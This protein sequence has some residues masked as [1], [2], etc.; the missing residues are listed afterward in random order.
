[1]SLAIKLLKHFNGFGLD[2]EWEMQNE[3]LVLF[4]HSGAGKS[5]TLQLIAG[6]I[7]PDAGFIRNGDQSYFDDQLSV[8]VPPQQRSF[9]FV[10]QDPAL[11][12][13]F[14]VRRN[15]EYG[16]K[17]LDKQD[18]RKRTDHMMELFQISDL[19]NKRPSEISGGQKQRVALARALIRRPKILLLD[20]PFSA[21][22]SPLRH[23]MREFLLSL[24]NI[25]QVPIVLVTH[26]TV[27]ARILADRIIVYTDGRIKRIGPPAEVLAA[28]DAEQEN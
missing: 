4:G 1:M 6:L 26:D 7:R 3:L 23:S 10:S 21:L 13:H 5:L 24:R 17:G 19:E 2:V 8:W 27:E 22:D 25:F 14:S 11:F 15:I 16:A 9:G 12:P 20:E 28:A 18:R